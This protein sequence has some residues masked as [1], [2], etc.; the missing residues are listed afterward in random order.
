MFV[1][2]IIFYIIF[3]NCKNLINNNLKMT[4]I[5]SFIIL[6]L[7]DLKKM[8][9]F[10]KNDFKTF[11]NSKSLFHCLILFFLTL[12]MNRCLIV[13]INNFLNIESINYTSHEEYVSDLVN[14]NYKK[15]LHSFFNLVIFYPVVE[16][17]F[18]R[19]ILYFIFNEYLNQYIVIFL[20]CTI[21]SLAHYN[22]VLTLNENIDTLIQM[23]F[24]SSIITIYFNFTKNLIVCI[25][26][27]VLYNF[28]CVIDWSI[29]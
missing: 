1:S 5:V 21:F 20:I 19:F 16:E 4:L 8:N 13:K 27:H 14:K 26:F 6:T 25:L 24:F 28:Y 18:Y 3:V 2:L 10:V 9:S 11:F 22:K 12:F 15:I 17:I 29:I 23:F 7:I